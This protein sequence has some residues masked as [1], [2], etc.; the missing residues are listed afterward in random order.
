MSAPS[1]KRRTSRPNRNQLRIESLENR[2]MMAG[3]LDP[4]FGY[5]FGITTT[6]F[7]KGSLISDLAFQ[8]DGRVV[9]LGKTSLGG[10]SSN[11]ALARYNSDGSL[12]TTFGGVGVPQGLTVTDFGQVYNESVSIAVLPDGK[13][14]TGG[15]SQF[16][17]GYNIS[18]ARYDSDG[19]LDASFANGGKLEIK[20][21]PG[22]SLELVEMVVTQDK[23]LL[24]SRTTLIHLNLDGS[25]DNSF[26]SNGWIEKSSFGLPPGVNFRSADYNNG[27]YTLGMRGVDQIEYV[28][29]LNGDG[30]LDQTFGSGGIVSMDFVIGSGSITK[31]LQ[32]DDGSVLGISEGSSDDIFKLDATG[33]PDSGFNVNGVYE[34]YASMSFN[35]IVEQPSGAIV[36]VGRGESPESQSLAMRLTHDGQ[37]DES[38][39][40]DGV[41]QFDLGSTNEAN[42]VLGYANGKVLLGGNLAGNFFLARLTGNASEPGNQIGDKSVSTDTTHQMIPMQS[43]GHW[44]VD[45][46]GSNTIGQMLNDYMSSPA[47]IVDRGGQVAPRTMTSRSTQNRSAGP[48]QDK[49]VQAID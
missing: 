9:A 8:A 22:D 14:L 19:A 40:I 43:I 41:R 25:A 21:D 47:L 12:D 5:G 33:S 7:D 32:L 28:M 1:S 29:R 23:I 13:I 30:S 15:S 36:A 38:F 17:L 2:Q 37:L 42:S 20:P 11:F 48:G 18:L 27:T 24:V 46:G 35:D 4:T 39:G 16:G 44:F 31:V 10:G 49:E 6:D 26:G 3:D 45:V 34:T